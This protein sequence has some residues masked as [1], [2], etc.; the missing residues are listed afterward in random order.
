MGLRVKL[1]STVIRIKQ[2]SS[3]FIRQ[4]GHSVSKLLKNCGKI[5]DAAVNVLGVFFLKH[6]VHVGVASVS[7]YGSNVG[8]MTNK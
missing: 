3:A 6:G 4:E 1:S 8:L 7:L 2:Q 5:I